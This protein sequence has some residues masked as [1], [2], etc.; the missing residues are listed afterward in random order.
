MSEDEMRAVSRAGA[1]LLKFVNAVMSYCD[2]LKEVRPKREKVAQLEKDFYAVSNHFCQ[3]SRRLETM[4]CFLNLEFLSKSSS[5]LP[6]TIQHLT[7]S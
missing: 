3:S 1:G 4:S 7:E 2:V 6:C 5:L